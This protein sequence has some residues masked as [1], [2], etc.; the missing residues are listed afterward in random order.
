MVPVGREE[1]MVSIDI[2]A[3][4]CTCFGG[5]YQRT[6]HTQLRISFLQ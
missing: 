5:D 3:V 4:A 2:V 1:H 6:L